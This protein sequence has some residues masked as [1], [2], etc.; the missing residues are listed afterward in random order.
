MP[1]APPTPLPMW[2]TAVAERAA[3]T[4]TDICSAEAGRALKSFQGSSLE[5]F[6]DNSFT[7][8]PL[9]HVSFWGTE[10]ETNR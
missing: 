10:W 5:S 9:S 6:L 2:S 1:S 3:S 4:G 8:K 7:D